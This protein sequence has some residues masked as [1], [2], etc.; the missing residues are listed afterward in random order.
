MARI[1]TGVSKKSNRENLAALNMI[2][3]WRNYGATG[4]LLTPE[5]AWAVSGGKFGNKP[6]MISAMPLAYAPEGTPSVDAVKVAKY[7]IKEQGGIA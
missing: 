3:E 6:V 4:F 2:L 7:I 5:F 1:A